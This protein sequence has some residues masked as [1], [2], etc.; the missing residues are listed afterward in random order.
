MAGGALSRRKA[1]RVLP[2]YTASVAPLRYTADVAPLRYTAEWGAVGI[3][4][5]RVRDAPV[6]E[7]IA[8][9]VSFSIH[10][11]RMPCPLHH[12]RTALRE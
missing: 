7:P 2:L 12:P 6:D 1:D 8:L 10:N 4:I 3:G 5:S 9:Q 11:A